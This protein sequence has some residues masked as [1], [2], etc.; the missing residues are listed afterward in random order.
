MPK[1]TNNPYCTV[2]IPKN[3]N[4]WKETDYNDMDNLEF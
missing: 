1:K 3:H 4:V 2:L